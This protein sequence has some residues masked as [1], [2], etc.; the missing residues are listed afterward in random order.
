MVL[1]P[2][3]PFST[4][5]TLALKATILLL[6]TLLIKARI[7]IAAFSSLGFFLLRLQAL[8]FLAV[9]GSLVMA[10]AGAA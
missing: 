8:V 5:N 9:G 4:V 7:R 2:F 1:N 10:A 3:W 6:L